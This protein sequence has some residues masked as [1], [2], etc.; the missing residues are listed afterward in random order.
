MGTACSVVDNLRDVERT[1][2]R[3]ESMPVAARLYGGAVIGTGALLLV[4]CFPRSVPDPLLFLTVLLLGIF[5]SAFKL[6]LPLSK[7]GATIS[8]SYVADLMALMLV[9][10]NLTMLMAGASAWSQCGLQLRRQTSVFRTLFSVAAIVITVQATGLAYTLLGGVPGHFDSPATVVRPLVAGAAV[11][12]SLNTFMVA[13]AIALATREQ[14]YKVWRDTFLWSAPSCFVGAG[15]AILAAWLLGTEAV[16]FT[17]L[18]LAPAYLTYRTHKVYLGRIEDERRHSEEIRGLHAQAMEALALARESQQ[19]LG[20]EKERLTVTL[21]SLGEAVVATGLDGRIL[22]ANHAA[23]LFAGRQQQEI[24]GRLLSEVFPTLESANSRS[25]TAQQGAAGRTGTDTE[26]PCRATLIAADGTRRLVEHTATPLRN[27]N[28]AAEGMV[29]VV[30]D[31]SDAARLEE[32]RQ[33]AGK[34]ASLGVLAGGIAHDFNNILTAIL[35]NISLAQMDP[36]LGPQTNQRLAE[37]ERACA[38]AKTLT[39]QLLTFSK[40]GAP[41]KKVLCVNDLIRESA[42]FVLRGTNARCEFSL[43]PAL[44]PVEADE[45]QMAQ[46]INNLVINAREAMPD[47]GVV[48][49]RSTNVQKDAGPSVR[50]EVEDRGVGI[51]QQNLARIF[52]PYFTTKHQGSGLGL[53]TCYSIV[54]N[55]GGH[56]EV[57]SAV[58]RGTTFSVTLPAHPGGLPAATEKQPGAKIGRG[59]VLVMDD[60]EPVRNLVR[61]MLGRLGYDAEVAADGRQAIEMYKR[62]MDERRVFDVVV[63][64]LTV[65]GGLGGKE[66]IGELRRLDPSVKAIVSSGYAEDPVMAQFERFGFSGVVPKPFG[67]AELSHALQLVLS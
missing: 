52:D 20:A 51:P 50:I 46:V 35:G 24:V 56:I 45:G 11:Y 57:K 42:A 19:A 25:C 30:R 6:S 64:D 66:A 27:D 22:L 61:M 60:E 4:A 53:A 41:L 7:S 63:M 36:A 43:G 18:A 38:R 10:P 62:A 34:L 23:E 31:V 49:I 58:G 40:G 55:H 39:H 3:R 1:R 47:G 17:P 44:W 32:E 16:W 5:S 8:V 37:A 67:S 14:P 48:V 15:V 54:R 9:G 21:R 65:P 12:F 26:S 33:K 2:R 29:V 28:G 13:A 59:R